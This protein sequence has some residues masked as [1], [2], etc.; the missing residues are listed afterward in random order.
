M[1]K[2]VAAILIKY[3][4]VFDEYPRTPTATAPEK[5]YLYQSESIFSENFLFDKKNVNKN[6]GTI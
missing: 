3:K 4:K 5:H 1:F 6:C 2:K